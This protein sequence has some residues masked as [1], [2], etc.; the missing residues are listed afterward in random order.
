MGLEEPSQAVALLDDLMSYIVVSFND[1]LHCYYPAECFGDIPSRANKFGEVAQWT[2]LGGTDCTRVRPL[3]LSDFVWYYG[4]RHG[5]RSI[6]STD[7]SG[8]CKQEPRKI[9][10]TRP[11]VKQTKRHLMFR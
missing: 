6:I 9:W 1:L 5:V 8:R 10:V 11:T 3:E 7:N 4:K 2:A